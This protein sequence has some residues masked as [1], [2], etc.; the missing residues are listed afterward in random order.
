MSIQFS[1]HDDNTDLNREVDENV[2]K[3][4]TEDELL[5]QDSNETT[6][7]EDESDEDEEN[8][9]LLLMSK[10][11]QRNAK[12][13]QRKLKNCSSSKSDWRNVKFLTEDDSSDTEDED[14]YEETTKFVSL[15][16]KAKEKNSKIKVSLVGGKMQITKLNNGYE[17]ELMYNAMKSKMN[18]SIIKK[19]AV[20]NKASDSKLPSEATESG[21]CGS[22]MVAITRKTDSTI[23]YR[24]TATS[25]GGKR[26]FADRMTLA[27]ASAEDFDNSQDYVD[28]LQDKLHGIK[29]KLIK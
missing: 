15:M 28:F 4:C 9:F 6:E 17:G 26:K 14:D 13:Q 3:E 8:K 22:G 18:Q 2:L 7:T 23:R 25:S 16:N 12:R 21:S 19:P 1:N 29:I 27:E 10:A 5:L 20:I 24:S 11:E